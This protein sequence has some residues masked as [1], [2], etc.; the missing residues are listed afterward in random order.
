MWWAT[1]RGVGM[2]DT[3]VAG[4]CRSYAAVV[5]TTAV[6]L[7][8]LAFAADFVDGAAGRVVAG[9]TSSGF[10][11]GLVAFL[12]GR[13]ATGAR[14]AAGGAAVLLVVATLLYYLLVLVVSRRWSGATLEDG[15]SADLQ[16]LRSIA[17]MTTVWLVGSLIAGPI[18]GL[19]GYVARTGRT[20][21]AAVA[22]GVTC[23]L[24]SGEGWQTLIRVQPWLL[25]AAG[26]RWTDFVHGV[27]VSELVKTA[28]LLA[29][30]VWLVRAHH[31]RRGLPMLLVA[32]TVSGLLSTLAWHSLYTV[33]NRI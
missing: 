1:D 29:V 19:L 13:A 23:G 3:A 21:S 10:V 27:V 15:T 5:A 20:L 9:L 4:P 8:L 14:Q 26:S 22:A 25:P 33:T 11:W 17:V 32:A 31:L 16:G 6:S 24:L 2:S 28:L 7:G 12:A 18:L 30:L